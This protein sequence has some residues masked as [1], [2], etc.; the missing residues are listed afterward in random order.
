MLWFGFGWLLILAF[1]WAGQY[2]NQPRL[3]LAVLPVALMLGLASVWGASPT[4]FVQAPTF[5]KQT[6]THF[7][8]LET[9]LPASDAV[10][11]SWWD[12]GYMSM[13]TNGKPTLHDG[14]SQTSPTTHFIANN[15]LRR[16]QKE[17]ALELN[18]LGNTGYAGVIAHRL[19][20]KENSIEAR[21]Y[22]TAIYLV[23]TQDMTRWMP[24]ISKIGAFDIEAG[25][26]YQF[27]GVNRATSCAMMT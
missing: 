4:N 22:D 7:Q 23:L 1:R 16:S 20:D 12:Y 13:L 15:L 11:A 8:K 5:D 10:V 17:A 24:S 9:L 21:S 27:D 18:V 14:G 6:V 2:L 25:K 19:K 26:P 3:Q